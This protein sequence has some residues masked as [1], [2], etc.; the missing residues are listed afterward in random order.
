MRREL[1]SAWADAPDKTHRFGIDV[2]SD[3][4]VGCAAYVLG[5]RARTHPE[6]RAVRIVRG[7]M[8][9]SLAFKS[10]R[11]SVTIQNAPPWAAAAAAKFAVTQRA[12]AAL[13][14]ST[15]PPGFVFSSVK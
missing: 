7:A 13:D 6:I 11:L 3:G 5:Q 10:A 14:L 4:A 8:C 12:V 2:S 1:V 9:I 15:P